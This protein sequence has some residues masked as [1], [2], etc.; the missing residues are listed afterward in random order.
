M[1]AYAEI[2]VTTNF[3]F[4]RGAAHPSEYADR[5]TQLGLA[6]IGIADRNT[7]AGVVRMYD[8]FKQIHEQT[9]GPVPR[10]LVGSRLVFV[11]GTPDILA[12]PTDR[13]AYGR[14]CR[15]LST[16]KSRA[17]KGECLLAFKDLLDWQDGLLLVVM[18]PYSH[19]GAPVEHPSEK[20]WNAD[21]AKQSGGPGIVPADA[22]ANR[23]RDTPDEIEDFLHTLKTAAPVRTWLGVS[24]HLRGDDER[25]LK[26][27]RQVAKAADVPLIAT[28]DVLYDVPD[29]RELQ[30]VVTC[31]REHVTLE[32]AGYR[33][34]ANAER[35][36]KEPDEMMELFRDAPEAIAET[37]RFAN[38]IDFSLAKL[39]YNYPNEPVPK[40]KTA[41]QHLVDLTWDGA[42][43]RYNGA[44]PEEVEDVLNKELSLIE[45]L[46]I[47][48]YFLTVYDIVSFAKN[49]EPE[50]LCQG[51]GS[52][53]NS[54]V[55]YALGI[56][57][58]NPTEVDLL[59]ERFV[60]QERKEP[61]DIDVDFEHERREEVI[62]YVYK[63]YGHAR[64]ALT[65]T[66]I[67]YRP[68]SAIR[69]TGKVFGLTEDIT[70]DLASS[71]WGSWGSRLSEDQVKQGKLDPFNLT[72]AR[73][74]KAAND[75]MGFPRH[76]SQHVGGFVLTQ[77]RLDETVPVSPATMEDRFFIEWD[78]DDLDA[79][80]L[81]KVDVL[82]LG[83]LTC[84]RKAF[85]LIRVHNSRTLELWKVPRED[86]V[87]YDMLCAA[88]AIGVFQV[89]SRAQMNMLPRLKPRKFYDLVVEVA[90]VRPG[91]I[92]GNMVHPY[93]KR[94]K[95]PE[96][97]SF[98][99]PLP[100][101]GKADELENVLGK[102]MGVPLFQEQ[103]MKLAMVAAKFTAEEANQLRRSMAT[104]RNVGTIG[105]FETKMVEGMVR[106]GYDRQFAVDCFNQI[107]GFGS[108]GFPESH[109]ASFSHLVYISAWIKKYYP[110][111]FAC[112]LL[113]SQPM[114][115]YAPAEIVR[116]AI[117]H[118]VMVH[119]VDVNES[120]WDNT[121]ESGPGRPIALRLGFRQIDG[122]SE[123]WA[124]L[125]VSRRGNR[126]SNVENLARRTRLPKRA[127]MIL[128]E[129]DCFQ[130]LAQDRRE[131]LWAVRRVPDD[132]DLP[133][134]AAQYVEEQSEEEI[135]PL[136]QM[137]ISEHVLADYQM[138]RLSLK[139][140][141][142]HFL[143][144]LFREEDIKSCHDVT[145]AGRDGEPAV[146]AG[147]VLTRQMPGD[148]G[149]VFVTLS[150]ETGIANVVVW[151]ALVETFRAEIM[152]ARLMVV[153]GK[154][155]RSPEGVVHL[156]AE[157]VFDRTHELDRLS[158]DYGGSAGRKW[159]GRHV[160]RHPRNV[161]VVP[162]SRD[163]H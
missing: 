35:F 114:G 121:L 81:M 134:F 13:A 80:G 131:A 88:N 57:S 149:V 120:Q 26:T 47:A 130:S 144:D 117:D 125:L 37:I 128:A 55:C 138:L 103:A 96:L 76:L 104:F 29:R 50:I 67:H 44:I 116:D 161:R 150:D 153:E 82:A 124:T 14:L 102:T 84:I 90:I 33:L 113:N 42:R 6:A 72:V 95:N 27:W 85:E 68:R 87:V 77:D 158:E 54:V 162:K 108:Y 17:P 79:V 4:L 109:A 119:H 24:L 16:G 118:G 51:R 132:D 154:I 99:K 107:R 49:Q 40:G 2:G 56:T 41:Q 78:K 115:F 163:F 127:L 19:R 89:E 46:E 70:A 63:R 86:P 10:Q 71:V 65:A 122:F 32:E 156:V 9:T 53:A 69:E 60:S 83:M 3:S 1:I 38:R 155:Q 73:A 143:R 129:A 25:W 48:P 18:P 20:F 30:D 142:M 74:V 159:K 137:P 100:E 43:K 136:P 21:L 94:R 140:H 22:F 152:G 160:H 157:R 59:F 75:M 91:P 36:L 45:R 151:P 92:Q 123:G 145:E 112:G 98:P 15:L 7:L 101:H 133:L 147:I 58:V 34:E 146:C 106:R 135:A 148:A 105:T 5:A 52:A 31:I 8:A 23:V 139:A 97:I 11:D 64:A 61:P 110:A 93:L 111:A 39:K 126:F 141:L 12:Y 62:Q 28:N 66:V